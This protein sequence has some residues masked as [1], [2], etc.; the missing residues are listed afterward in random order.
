MEIESKSIGEAW[1]KAT[2]L[3][4]DKGGTVHDD[5]TELR[6]IID[7]SITISD[8][9][10][11]D[12]IVEKSG[13]RG[14]LEWMSANFMDK[15][16]LEKWGYSYGQRIFDYEGINQFE[17]VAK[18]LKTNPESKSA[19]ISLMYPPGDK[20][21]VPCVCIIDF[22]LRDGRLDLFCVMRSQDIFKKNY[23]DA[24]VLGQILKNMAEKIGAEPGSLVLKIISAHIYEQDFEGAETLVKEATR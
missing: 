22:K 3:V 19:T 14:M 9:T 18:K 16:P 2:G 13:D 12:E 17:E 10:K 6:E 5:G 7:L 23:A 8:P 24:R 1:V 4:M 15:T 20:K 21:H 11:T